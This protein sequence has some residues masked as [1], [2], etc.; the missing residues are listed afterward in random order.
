MKQL[1]ALDG[2]TIVLALASFILPFALNYN[3]ERLIHNTAT[4]IILL[5][6]VFIK[7]KKIKISIAV[8]CMLANLYAYY[9]LINL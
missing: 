6:N 2:F 8:L 1:S 7:N 4:G 3:A 5:S 9:N